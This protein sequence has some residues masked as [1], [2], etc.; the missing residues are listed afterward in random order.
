MPFDLIFQKNHRKYIFIYLRK[1]TKEISISFRMS[2]N[3]I[4]LKAVFNI[5]LKFL[6]DICLFEMYCFI[7]ALETVFYIGGNCSVAKIVLLQINFLE[8]NILFYR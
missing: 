4:A 7:V 8:I 6:F 2:R 1:N 5:L 3:E